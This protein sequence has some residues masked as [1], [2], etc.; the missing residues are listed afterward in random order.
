MTA[1]TKRY[2]QTQFGD[3]YTIQFRPQPSGT[4][5]L[6]C[7]DH[8]YNPYSD[9]AAKCHLYSSGEIC[10][11]HGCEPRTLDRAK[12]IATAFMDGYS[13]YVRTGVFPNGGKRVSVF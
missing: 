11:S 8:P 2:R 6:F 1:D 13:Q 9:D 3:L 7:L 12:A 10:V 4:V 5:K